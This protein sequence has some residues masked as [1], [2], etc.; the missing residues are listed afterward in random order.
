[1]SPMKYPKNIFCLRLLGYKSIHYV[2]SFLLQIAIVAFRDETVDLRLYIKDLGGEF[3]FCCI[4][5]Q[6]L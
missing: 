3:T 6:F 2:N 4:M 5:K 1:M